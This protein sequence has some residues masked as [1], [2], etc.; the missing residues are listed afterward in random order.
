MN[1]KEKTASFFPTYFSNTS[2]FLR[3]QARRHVKIL[4]PVMMSWLAMMLRLV[5]SMIA[6]VVMAP[7]LA[8]AP[9]S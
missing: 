1:R 8:M 6:R 9:A 5:L 2:S 7:R 4:R 3:S